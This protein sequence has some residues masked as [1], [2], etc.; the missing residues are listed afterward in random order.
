MSPVTG[1]RIDESSDRL[2][3]ALWCARDCQVESGHLRLNERE[4]RAQ[5]PGGG[6]ASAL[7][8]EERSVLAGRLPK[9][10]QFRGDGPERATQ[11]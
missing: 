11:S 3:C 2:L 4:H 5:N 9:G 1:K 6:L 8:G 10:G 7:T